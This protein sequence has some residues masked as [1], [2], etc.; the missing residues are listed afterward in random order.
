[1]KSK[2]SKQKLFEMM[3]KLNSDFRKLNEQNE[4]PLYHIKNE[5]DGLEGF[6]YKNYKEGF[7]AVFRDM[8]SQENIGIKIFPEIENA[9]KWLN[10]VINK[11]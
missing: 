4:T 7:N 5:S 6:I 10:G 9:K 8:D 1:M 2:N 11:N 3:E